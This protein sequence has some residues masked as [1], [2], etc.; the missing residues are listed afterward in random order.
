MSHFD[1]RKDSSLDLLIKLLGIGEGW[2]L[3]RNKQLV[4]RIK[5]D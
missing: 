3:F 4:W 2:P 5:L 1:K